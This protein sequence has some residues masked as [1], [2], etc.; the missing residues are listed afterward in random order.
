MDLTWGEAEKIAKNKEEWKS[1]VL[2]LC[3]NG[4]NKDQVHV[5]M[6]VFKLKLTKE[7]VQFWGGGKSIYIN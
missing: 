7:M 1:L 6:Q 2:A 3:A 4:C 5:G